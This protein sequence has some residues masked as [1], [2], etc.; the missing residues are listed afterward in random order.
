MSSDFLGDYQ[1][2]VDKE[3]QK[4]HEEA[5]KDFDKGET[6]DGKDMDDRIGYEHDMLQDH[7]RRLRYLEERYGKD[8]PTVKD[9]EKKTLKEGEKEQK[10]MDKDDEKK[11][12]DK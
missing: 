1:K 5:G 8:S 4:Q 3:L 2:K 7:E 10:T 6:K 12:G 9:E 11:G